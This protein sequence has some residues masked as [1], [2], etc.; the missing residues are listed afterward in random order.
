[1]LQAHHEPREEPLTNAQRLLKLP[2]ISLLKTPQLWWGSSSAGASEVGEQPRT[3]DPSKKPDLEAPHVGKRTNTMKLLPTGQPSTFSPK[4]QTSS[5]IWPNCCLP[6][7]RA[8]RAQGRADAD[9]NKEEEPLD[10]LFG[11]AT[12]TE[13]IF[14]MRSAPGKGSCG[15]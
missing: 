1:M 2:S 7:P 10:K 4:E 8:K 9:G 11:D 6:L 12:R 5:H 15:T 13:G 14:N 3:T